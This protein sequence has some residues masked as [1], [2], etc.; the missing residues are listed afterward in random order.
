MHYNTTRPTL[1]R[2]FQPD[3]NGTV[4]VQA[5]SAAT[6]MGVYRRGDKGNEPTGRK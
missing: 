1:S 2:S 6:I 4:V 5:V 3:P